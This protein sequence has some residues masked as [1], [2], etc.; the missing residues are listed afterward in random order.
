ML[1]LRHWFLAIVIA[2]S[3]TSCFQKQLVVQTRYFSHEDLASFYVNTPDPL[4][5]DPPFGQSLLI[6][7]QLDRDSCRSKNIEITYRIR[8]RNKTEIQESL[9]VNKLSGFY[10]YSIFND[11]YFNSGGILTYKV[12]LIVDGHI[13]EEWRQQLWK[14]L[15]IFDN[16]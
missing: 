16:K 4:Q 2:M 5:N 9:K 15:I 10:T 12:D 3:L 6:F 8:F 11:D 7:W 1:N 14:E 13:V